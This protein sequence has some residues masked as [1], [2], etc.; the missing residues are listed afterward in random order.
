MYIWLSALFNKQQQQILWRNRKK[1]QRNILETTYGTRNL[2]CCRRQTTQIREEIQACFK[3]I[4]MFTSTTLTWRLP[5]SY[6]SFCLTVAVQSCHGW[7]VSSLLRFN[8][9]FCRLC[10]ETSFRGGHSMFLWHMICSVVHFFCPSIIIIEK[11]LQIN[12]AQ[13]WLSKLG[14][15]FFSLIR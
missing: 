3:V 5:C 6:T 14:K 8:L 9:P 1:K 15:W 12:S 10:D 11:S 7:I 4:Y 2:K 13:V